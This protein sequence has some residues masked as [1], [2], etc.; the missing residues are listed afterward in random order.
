MLVLA[1]IGLVKSDDGFLPNEAPPAKEELPEYTAAE[2]KNELEQGAAF[3]SLV[4]EVQDVYKRQS[5]LFT[6]M[7]MDTWVMPSP[8]SRAERA[9]NLT[10]SELRT[11]AISITS[12]CLSRDM[13]LSEVWYASF[14]VSFAQ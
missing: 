7:A 1:G 9:L 12:P 4:A 10:L 3:K 11:V 14:S 8:V 13:I 2:I 5:R 6:S